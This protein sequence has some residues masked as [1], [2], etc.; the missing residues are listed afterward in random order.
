M[1]SRFAGSKDAASHSQ[2][3]LVI[4]LRNFDT[5]AYMNCEDNLFVCEMYESH[6]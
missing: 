5:Q 1:P 6:A 3:I 4:A 2:G